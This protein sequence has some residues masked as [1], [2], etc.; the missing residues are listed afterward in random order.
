MRHQLIAALSLV[1]VS[2]FL[3]SCDE[4]WTRFE[5]VELEATGIELKKKNVLSYYGE[6]PASGGEITLTAIGKHKNS[7]VLSGV[8]PPEPCLELAGLTRNGSFPTTVCDETW[9][10]VAILSD[11]PHTTRI[12]FNVNTTEKNLDYLFM[13]GTAYIVAEVYI[14]QLAQ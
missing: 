13:F 11:D 5:L 7:G 9:G 3:F 4:E 14:T 10:K 6:I 1:V 2:L 12:T 8:Y